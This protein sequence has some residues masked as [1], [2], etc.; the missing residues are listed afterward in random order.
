MTIIL[1]LIEIVIGGVFLW[2]AAR[3]TKVELEFKEIL[4]CVLSASFASF[5][6]TV[7]WFA[8]IIVLFLLL[9]RFSSANI[10]PDLILMVLVS[11]LFVMMS[12][13]FLTGIVQ[14]V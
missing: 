8:S 10:W 5:I 11:R 1:F 2:F 6:P 14:T 7:G 13:F 9:K 3:V 12:L 4:I